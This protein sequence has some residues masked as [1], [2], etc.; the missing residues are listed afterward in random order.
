MPSNLHG[1]A[2]ANHAKRAG[3]FAVWRACKRSHCALSATRPRVDSPSADPCLETVP[4]CCSNRERGPDT[5]GCEALLQRSRDFLAG[6]WDARGRSTCKGAGHTRAQTCGGMRSPALAAPFRQL[7][8]AQT[9][10]PAGA[11]ARCAC[12]P[13]QRSAGRAGSARRRRHCQA[14]RAAKR[15]TAAALSGAT[16]AHYK[17]LLDDAEARELLAHAANLLV[18]AR[19]HANVAAA[20]GLSRL[21]ARL[22]AGGSVRDRSR[23]RYWR[24]VPASRVTQP[25]QDFCRYVR[26]T[27]DEATGP[28][29]FALQTRAGTDALS[30][31]LRA[32]VDLD[33]AATIVSL[34]CRSA[35]DTI[36]RSTF[37]RKLHAVAPATVPFVL[38]WHGQ[39]STYYWWDHLSG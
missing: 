1:T 16:C 33:S 23:H 7:L 27:F 6:R 32:A 2:C 4:V 15:G 26:N 19:V 20:M 8:R 22:K 30:G 24:Y 11:P 12:C 28:H 18:A 37:L 3:L 17:L 31:M 10:P 34:D 5:V 13:A 39:Q 9:T 38:L 36:S 29:Q 14:L 25:C 21:T 35:Y